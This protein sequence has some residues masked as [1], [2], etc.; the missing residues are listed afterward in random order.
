MSLHNSDQSVSPDNKVKV[1]SD[2]SE[3]DRSAWSAFVFNHPEANIFHTPEYFDLCNSIETYSGVVVAFLKDGKICGLLVAAIQ[4]EFSS[5]AGSFT[6]RAVSWGGPLADSSDIGI[7]ARLIEG[8]NEAVK[9]RVLFSQF[10][11]LSDISSYAEVFKANGYD[12]EDH[13]N[14]IFDLKSGKES[15]WAAVHSARRNK[16]NISRKRSCIT[17]AN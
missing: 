6:A 7:A 5:I 11:N 4:R 17:T 10:R 12:Y 14:I 15:L 3:I 16:I 8:Y 9:G 13:L 2:P 1:T